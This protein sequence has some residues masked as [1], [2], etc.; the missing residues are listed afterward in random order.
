[1]LL[2]EGDVFGSLIKAPHS[3]FSASFDLESLADLFVLFLA[4]SEQ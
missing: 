2:Y 3:Y 4:D 1:M